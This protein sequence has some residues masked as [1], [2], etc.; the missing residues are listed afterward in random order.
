MATAQPTKAETTLQDEIKKL[1]QQLAE[2]TALL[3]KQ[4][5]EQIS[6]LVQSF[7]AEIEKNGFDRVAVKKAVLEKLTRKHKTRK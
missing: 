5:S 7:L 1:E 2:K 6:T 4:Q 3:N